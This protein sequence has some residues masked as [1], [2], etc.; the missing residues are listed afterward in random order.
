MKNSRLREFFQLILLAALAAF[1]FITTA[2]QLTKYVN[3]FI[4]T[5]AHG[6]TY[7][8]ATVPFWMLQFSPDNG[9]QGWDW[10]SGYH[11]TDSM[12]AGFNLG[13]A[14]NF[15]SAVETFI[16]KLNNSTIAVEHKAMYTEGNAWQHSFFVP[17]DVKG[18]A[19]AHGSN[20]LFIKKLDSLFNVS[21][22]LSGG[23]TSPDESGLIGQYAHGNEPSHHIAY[24]YTYVGQ[25]WKTQERVRTIIDSMYHARPDGYACNE[26]GGQM[27]AWGV[28]SMA[29]LYPGNS[30]GGQY[31]F[32]STQFDEVKF[33]M[34][35]N[36]TFVIRAKNAGKGRPYIQSIQLNNHPNNKTYI[37][38]AA[39][40][41]GGVL[42]FIMGDK[43]NKI[44]GQLPA[45]WPEFASS[46]Q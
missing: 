34:A 40:I 17:H 25:A 4:G 24:M 36:K 14:I 27:S 8:G 19:T 44:F 6:H 18:L 28:W 46:E 38:H 30:S 42:E 5:G 43:P 1:P 35:G 10:C 32:E 39:M 3:P 12:I 9:T 7:A 37:Q 22:R 41:N 15:D 29:G 21:S 2:R 45:A 13:F 23:N 16:E 33:K 26:D 20:D 31:V 11:Y